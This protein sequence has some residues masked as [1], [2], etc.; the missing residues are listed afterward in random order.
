MAK[1][2]TFE[3]FIDKERARL[4]ERREEVIAKRS[5]LD[6]ELQSIER[7]LHAIETYERAKSGKAP[8]GSGRAGRR[9]TGRRGEKRQKVLD[10]IKRHPNGLSRK[11]ILV[12]LGVKGDRS[13]EQSVSNSL[14]ALK[15]TKQ[16][17]SR[18]GKYVA[19]RGSVDGAAMQRSSRAA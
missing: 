13:A 3:A 9:G 16:V 10:L 15:K 11:D 8:R 19:Q 4:K 18:E 5:E 7:E 6:N 2:D 1:A 17:A 12:N 14:A